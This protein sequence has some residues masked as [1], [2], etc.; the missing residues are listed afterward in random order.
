VPLCALGALLIARPAAA[1]DPS[2]AWRIIETDHFRVYT[3]PSYHDV[4]LRAAAEA[5][6]AWAALAQL[7]TP[8]RGRINLVVAN[9][10]DYANGFATTYPTP[11]VVLYAVPPAADVELAEY[12]RWLRLVITHELVHVFHLNLVRGWWGAAQDV[13]GRAPGLFPN[14]YTPTWLK[15]GAAVFYE[16]KITGEG[17]LEGSYHRAIVRAQVAEVGPLAMGAA[18][19]IGPRW[20]GG[21]RPY[22]FGATFFDYLLSARGDTI[23]PRLFDAIARRPLPWIELNADLTAAAGLS[24]TAAWDDWMRAAVADARASVPGAAEEIVIACCQRM[25]EQPRL[26]PDERRLLFV[27]YDG[28][29]VPRLAV[30]DRDAGTVRDVARVNTDEGVAWRGADMLVAQLEFTGPYTERSD[31]WQVSARGHTRRLTHA[32]R[33]RQPDAAP[34]GAIVAVRTVPDG[35]ELVMLDGDSARA[36]VPARPGVEWASP[37]FSPDGRTIAAIRVVD[38]QHDVV[39]LGRDGALVRQVTNDSAIDR[40]PAWTP[41]GAWVLW[42]HEIE[43][44]SQIVGM[45]LADGGTF[46]FTTA[47]FGAYAPA[48]ATDS[49]FYL[50]YHAD[51]FRLVAVPLRGLPWTPEPG[52]RAAPPTPPQPPYRDLPARPF[53]ALLPHYWL[54]AAV[55]AAP[56]LLVGALTAGEDPLGRHV[57]YA[58]FGVGTGAARGRWRGAVSYAYTGV[59]PLVF[60]VEASREQDTYLIGTAGALRSACCLAED[61]VGAGATVLDRHWRTTLDARFGG[62][63]DGVERFERRAGVSLSAGASHVLAAPLAISAQGGWV[64]S[65]R[66]RYRRRQDAPLSATDVTLAGA[67][68]VPG[69]RVGFARQV[70]A[71]RAAAGFIAGSD[72]VSYGV[73]GVSGGTFQPVP[74]VVLG[75]GGQSFPVRGYP[76]SWLAGRTT[77]SVAAEVRTPLALVGDGPGLFPPVTLDRLST[78]LFFDAGAAWSSRY[79]AAGAGGPAPECRRVVSSAGGELAIDAGVTYDFPVRVRLGAAWRFSLRSAAVYAAVGST[80]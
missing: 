8:P 50:S 20:P 17:R 71:V 66:A 18:G 11:T 79:C 38:G 39:L 1:Q 46:R 40:T 65:A 25:T 35:N 4:G 55:T 69:A 42:A 56:G 44:V 3:R 62:E 9:N 54:P 12:D 70:F 15:E 75:G 53:P 72:S 30:W 7:L 21:V 34:D 78:T 58:D 51:G 43:G 67:A 16:S 63:Y 61:R 29:D 23:M 32:A 73:G 33:L 36:L 26:S 74:G 59:S 24:F 10:V 47:P 19:G 27:R 76:G 2:G 68:Y 45:R 37:R 6:A 60:D 14:E 57:Y 52:L 64:V 28:R 41:D 13:F 22:A 31:L 5:E 49:L 77:A 80:F 48:P